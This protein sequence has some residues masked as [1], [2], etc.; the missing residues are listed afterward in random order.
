MISTK[1]LFAKWRGQ[2]MTE[3]II[4]VGLIAI[5]LIGGVQA[6]RNSVNEA[7]EGTTDTVNRFGIGTGTG[8]A[9]TATA[10][11]GSVGTLANGTH[12]VQDPASGELRLGSASG[13]KYDR[14]RDG[15]IQ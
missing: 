7:I 10:P 4:L 8:P 12:V 13:P 11:P 15:A 1:R 9:P 6:Y 3:Y 2:G 14:T 5:L